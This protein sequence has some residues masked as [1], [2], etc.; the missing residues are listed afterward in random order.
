MPKRYVLGQGAVNELRNIRTLI[1]GEIEG[2]LSL[3]RG[4]NSGGGRT[5]RQGE[6]ISHNFSYPSSGNT[7]EVILGDP[8]FDV[9]AVGN[10]TSTFEA[11]DNKDEW[12]R[13]CHSIDN[14]YYEEGTRVHVARINERWYILGSGGGSTSTGSTIL[15]EI[16]TESGVSEAASND[17]DAKLGDAL[18]TYRA[19]VTWRPC[20]VTR[21]PDEDDDGFVDVID[22]LGSFLDGR[23]NSE[24]QGKTGVAVYLVEDGGY[25]CQWV[26]TWIDWFREIQVIHDI[27]HTEEEIRFKVKRI[28]TWDDCDLD[29]IVIPLID[30]QDGS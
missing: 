11:Y 30:C 7:F 29:D 3:T 24:V 6:T 19:R 18:A 23:E 1:K 2:Q 5:V 20:G 10:Q 27:I 22:P 14:T 9:E 15:F 8:E 26:I 13:V 16:A 12:V 25:N 17:C 28:K 21:V 4:N